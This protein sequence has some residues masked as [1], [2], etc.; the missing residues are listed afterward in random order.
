MALIVRHQHR[1]GLVLTIG[2]HFVDRDLGQEP[3]GVLRRLVGTGV[4]G[5]LVVAHGVT[6][7]DVEEIARH[8]ALHAKGGSTSVSQ[9]RKAGR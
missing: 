9:A 5:S 7:M 1:K 6:I 2:W 3:L 8:R 4:F